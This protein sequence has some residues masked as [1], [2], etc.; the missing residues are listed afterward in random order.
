MNAN[1]E[2]EKN[3]HRDNRKYAVRFVAIVLLSA[4]VGAVFGYCSNGVLP[5]DVRAALDAGSAA[6]TRNAPWL[7]AGTLLLG[8]AICLALVLRA[9][10][11]L[12]RWD[13]EDE[14][15]CNAIENRLNWVICVSN[16]MVVLAMLLFA[17][18]IMAMD[19]LSRMAALIGFLSF[20]LSLAGSILFQQQV[21]DLSRVINPE[22]AV[23]VYDPRFQRKLLSLCDERERQQIGQ[24]SYAAFRAFNV[25]CPALWL[26][27][28]IGNLLSDGWLGVA[29][30]IVVAILWGTASTVYVI[31]SIRLE[32]M[33]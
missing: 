24:A 30:A 10:A 2:N 17:L 21:M 19:Q 7:L 28:M 29:P 13:G 33:K 3:I 16:L 22:K 9:R 23:S 14:R 27:L 25:L 26:L 11:A 15:T 8:T 32:K 1:P 31:S 6:L 20:I 4:I 18:G 12:K 5:Q